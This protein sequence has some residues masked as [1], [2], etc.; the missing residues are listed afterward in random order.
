MRQ[1][2]AVPPLGLRAPTTMSRHIAAALLV[3]L[4]IDGRVYPD[5]PV[6]WWILLATVWLVAA[7]CVVAES[8]VRRDDWRRCRECLEG[9]SAWDVYIM[10]DRIAESLQQMQRL[11]AG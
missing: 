7:T 4:A 2:A 3:A 8:R 1:S 6:A 10:V 9:K 11:A 5:I